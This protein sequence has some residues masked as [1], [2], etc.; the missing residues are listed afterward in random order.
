M[1]EYICPACGYVY[2]ENVGDIDNGIEPGTSFEDLPDDWICP[3][4]GLPKSEFQIKE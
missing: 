4:C 1:I 2:D 3:I